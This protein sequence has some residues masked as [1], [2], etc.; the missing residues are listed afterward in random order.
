MG[1]GW[2]CELKGDWVGRGSWGWVGGVNK[3]VMGVG[4]V[5]W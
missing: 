3:K 2:R 4:G 5:G 1:V